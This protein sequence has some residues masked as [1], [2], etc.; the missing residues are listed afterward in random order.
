[1]N[2]E[3]LVSFQINLLFFLKLKQ[4]A[5]ALCSLQKGWWGGTRSVDDQVFFQGNSPASNLGSLLFAGWATAGT[6]HLAC[7][8]P[9]RINL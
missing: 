6:H 3:G 5:S 9:L 4:F 8:L 1:M 2:F 7:Q